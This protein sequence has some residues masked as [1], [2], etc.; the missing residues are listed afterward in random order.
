MQ[1]RKHT[2]WRKSRKFGDVFGGRT[3]MKLTDGIF[4]RLHPFAAPTEGQSIPIVIED[5]PSKDFFFPMS[6]EE[7]LQALRQLPVEDVTGITHLWLRRIRKCDFESGQH[8]LAEFVCGGG[9]RLIVLYPWPKA[10]LLPLGTKKPLDSVLNVY[11]RWTTDLREQ[12]GEWCLGWT[13]PALRSFYV[14]YLLYHEVGHHVDRYT[15]RWGK[16]NRRLIESFADNYAVQ[17]RA[18]GTLVHA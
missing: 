15:R 10:M 17:W 6:G 18:R 13:L 5:N 4:Q 7:T 3:R 1:S 14:E 8:P 16:A 12:D 9:V 11:S 2:A